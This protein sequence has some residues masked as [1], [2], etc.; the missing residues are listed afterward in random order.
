MNVNSLW[1]QYETT[2][3]FTAPELGGHYLTGAASASVILGPGETKEVT[4]ILGWYFPDRDFLGLPVGKFVS[5][6]SEPSN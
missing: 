1:K 3:E 6:R 2:G 4:I 5:E